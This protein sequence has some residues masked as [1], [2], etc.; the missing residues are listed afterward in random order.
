[1]INSLPTCYEVVSG[2]AMEPGGGQQQRAAGAVGRPPKKQQQ[3]AVRVKG[4]RV[5]LGRAADGW[6][7][8]PSTSG[9]ALCAG[10]SSS[11]VGVCTRTCGSGHVILTV[12]RAVSCFVMLCAPHP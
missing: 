10:G 4:G 7:R 1:M 5:L 11:S 8:Q 2:K 3:V 9:V 12:L 6:D